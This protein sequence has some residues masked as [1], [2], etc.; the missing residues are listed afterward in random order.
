MILICF[1]YG[2]IDRPLA[3]IAQ[4]GLSRNSVLDSNGSVLLGGDFE[5][6]DDSECTKKQ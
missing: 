5:R 2:V 4:N 3:F 6:I 1:K